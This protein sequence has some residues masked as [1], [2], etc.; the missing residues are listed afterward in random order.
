MHIHILMYTYTIYTH[1]D[2]HALGGGCNFLQKHDSYCSSPG[3]THKDEKWQKQF[4]KMDACTSSFLVQKIEILGNDN[5]LLKFRVLFLFRLAYI[6][7][8]IHFK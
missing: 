1:T 5:P 8:L 6:Y 7:E 2:T 3:V 4:T